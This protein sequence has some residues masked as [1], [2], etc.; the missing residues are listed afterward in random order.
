VSLEIRQMLQ[1]HAEEIASWRYPEPYSF[2]DA[3]A[4]PGDLALLLDAEARRGRYFAAFGDNAA[5]VGFFEFR[6][7]GDE[8]VVGLGLRPDLTGR[9]FGL[10]F[11]EQG[12][13]FA[14]E[15][16]EPAAFRLSVAAFNER[17]IRVYERAGFERVRIF[18]HETAGAVH[19]FVEMAR[20]A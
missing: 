3:D 11:L 7:E 19:P 9:G 20:Q 12:L 1:A 16:F 13:A 5:L 8:V 15:R 4:D 18:D 2:Y 6:T 17:A 14:R 10:A